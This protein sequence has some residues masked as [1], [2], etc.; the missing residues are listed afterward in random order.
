MDEQLVGTLTYHDYKADVYSSSVPGEFRIVY[1]DP[2]GKE[3]E[4]A[5]LTGISTYHQ[6]E[7]EILQRLHKLSEGA[8]PRRTPDLGDAGEY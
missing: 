2:G 7:N 8:P 5:P 4:Q 6:R 1:R 3:L